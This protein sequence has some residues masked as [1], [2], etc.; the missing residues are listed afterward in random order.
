[1]KKWGMFG[2]T[3]AEP[4]IG[5][6]VTMPGDP[7][8]FVDCQHQV[9]IEDDVFFGHGVRILTGSH[10]YTKFGAERQ[11]TIVTKPVTI[12][13]GAWIASHAIILPGVTVGKHAVV[14][15]GAVVTKDVEEK[16]VV[17]GNP[18]KVIKKI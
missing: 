9:T 7:P 13:E 11:T 17:A 10:D 2:P 1:M 15:A 6:N 4:I 5:K 16:T 12:K 18:A 3:C 8:L 14:G